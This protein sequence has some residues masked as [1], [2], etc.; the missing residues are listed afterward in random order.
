MS[1]AVKHLVEAWRA[2]LL[3]LRSILHSGC[4]PARSLWRAADPG[5]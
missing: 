5:D 4:T 2:F 3:R 1:N